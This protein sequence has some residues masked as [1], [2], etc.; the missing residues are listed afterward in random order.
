MT[1]LNAAVR[2]LP[3]D[4]EHLDNEISV[5]FRKLSAGTAS[6]EEISE[7]TRLMRKRADRMMPGIFLDI[8]VV[9]KK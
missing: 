8:P 5:R 9:K 2:E 7:G 4:T 6:S 3:S 1:P